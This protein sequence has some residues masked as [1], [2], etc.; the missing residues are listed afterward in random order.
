MQHT[1]DAHLDLILKSSTQLIITAREW[2]GSF[3]LNGLS[4]NRYLGSMM[5]AFRYCRL[6][7]SPRPC[8]ILTD[9]FVPGRV[10]RADIWSSRS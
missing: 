9:P 1:Y 3:N 10:D 4:E 6:S 5:E 2:V 8:E 7:L